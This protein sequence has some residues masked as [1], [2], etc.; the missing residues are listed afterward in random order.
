MTIERSFPQ[1]R[2]SR[3]QY[4]Q[5]QTALVLLSADQAQLEDWEEQIE[6]F[7][8]ER[9]HLHLNERRRLRPV[10]DGID[11]LGKGV[12]KDLF[13]GERVDGGRLV[14]LIC[15]LGQGH[16]QIP[17]LGCADVCLRL[18]RLMFQTFSPSQE[19]GSC[20][21]VER[22]TTHILRTKGYCL[23]YHYA[24][25]KQHPSAVLLTLNP[26]AFLFHLVLE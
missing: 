12:F 26:L 17:R 4:M 8:A 1:K 2:E 14:H 24:H 6:A 16:P 21:K 20:L 25:G 3:T 7:L 15:R 13:P 22:E 11:F 5:L 19:E 23:E 9:L 18:E 10:A